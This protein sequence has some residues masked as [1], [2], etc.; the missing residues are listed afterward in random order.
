MRRADHVRYE[1]DGVILEGQL[2]A[3]GTRFRPLATPQRILIQGVAFF[4]TLSHA[5][6]E[7]SNGIELHPLVF[8]E[9]Q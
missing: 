2:G 3:P 7:A 4:D 1:P 5:G 9:F 8:L 6:G